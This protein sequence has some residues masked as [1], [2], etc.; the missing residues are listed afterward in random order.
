MSRHM[1]KYAVVA[2][3]RATSAR[4]AEGE[5]PDADPLAEPAGGPL[6]SRDVEPVDPVALQPT[7]NSVTR[8]EPTLPAARPAGVR[9][10]KTTTVTS[11]R[12]R[13]RS[14][15]PTHERFQI[16]RFAPFPL[17]GANA[18]RHAPSSKRE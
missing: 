3:E 13:C 14:R 15:H 4:E 9:A 11:P 7:I 8:A 12:E 16:Y 18:T 17:Q 2:C 10:P 6:P 1:S 5:D